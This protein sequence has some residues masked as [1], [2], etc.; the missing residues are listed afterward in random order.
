MEEDTLKDKKATGQKKS[1]INMLIIIFQ[2]IGASDSN[3]ED[4]R[5]SS[6]DDSN[7]SFTWSAKVGAPDILNRN[8][9]LQLEH[10]Q[11]YE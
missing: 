2:N 11:A 6:P 7:T 5:V 4:I 1:Y 8:D 3:E 9:F 10:E